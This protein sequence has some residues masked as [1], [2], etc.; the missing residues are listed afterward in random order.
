MI[1]ETITYTCRVCKSTQI[2]RNGTNRYG[3]AQYHCKDCGAYRVLKP[4]PTS[5]EIE[6]QIVLRACLER[7][8]LHGVERIVGVA[9]QTVAQ[10][11]K[12]HVQKLPDIEDMLLPAQAGDVLELDA[13]LELCAQ[14]SPHPLAVDCLVPSNAS[15]RRFR[16]WRSKQGNLPSL[17]G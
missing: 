4:K 16:N 2:V 6:Q 3:K 5:S 15:N 12:V 13:H 7:S 9:R 8:S 10:W 17:M 1:Q 14:T 11:I